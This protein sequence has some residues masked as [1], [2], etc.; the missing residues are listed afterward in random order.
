MQARPLSG[1]GVAYYQMDMCGSPLVP[2]H[3]REELA[4]RA[5]IGDLTS[6]V[7]KLVKPFGG[8]LLGSADCRF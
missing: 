8:Q 4:G 3:E 1:G 5:V 7:R 6:G 2:V